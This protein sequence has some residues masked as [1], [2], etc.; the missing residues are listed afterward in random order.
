M[1]DIIKAEIENSIDV[2]NKILMDDNIV[3]KIFDIGIDIWNTLN[4]GNK[5]FLCGNGGSAA[6]AQHI[7]A[8][9]VV[10]YVPNTGRPPL[11]AM[12]L[13]TDS[14]VLTAC[15]NDFGYNKIFSQQLKAFGNSGDIVI[16]IS[17]SGN[18]S[19]L[20]EAAHTANELGIKTIGL[21]GGLGGSLLGLCKDDVV[22]PSN[23]TARIQE[24]HIMIGHIWCEITERKWSD[25]Q[26]ILRDM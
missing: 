18:S 9:F 25:K 5:V 8:E 3:N 26:R 7:A 24:A 13:T 22:V 6:D 10:R 20:I 4:R 11:P 23:I 2:K 19:N 1:I 21:L 16:L 17:T 12:A 14:S 15:G